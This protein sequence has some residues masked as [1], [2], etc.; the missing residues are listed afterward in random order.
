VEKIHQ[1]LGRKVEMIPEASM[2]QLLHYAWPGN[3]RELENAL[4][5]AVLLSPSEILLPETLELEPHT[6]VQALPL[7]ILSLAELEKAHIENI[8][9]FTGYEKKRTAEIL[10]LSRPTLNAR[11][12]GYGISLPEK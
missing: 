11:I 7:M 5:R 3:V 8:L 9:Q 2:Q 10:G 4:R 6:P 12:K 1:E